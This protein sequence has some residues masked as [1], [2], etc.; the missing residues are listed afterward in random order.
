MTALIRA[1]L[2]KQRSIPTGRGLLVGMLTLIVF[3][4]LLHGLSLPP[5]NVAAREAQLDFVFRWGALFGSLFAS[6]LGA[7]SITGE[8]RHGTIRPTLLL[9][10]RRERV[11]AA[12]VLAAVV[13]GSAFGVLAVLASIAAAVA[14]LDARSIEVALDGADYALLLFGG[15]ATAALWAAI[16]VGLGAIVRQQVATVAGLAIWLLFIES[17]LVPFVPDVGRLAPGAAGVALAG[18]DLDALLGPAA[19]GALLVAYAIAAVIAGSFALARR[20]VG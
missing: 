1:E 2:L 14:S 10:P 5:D 16:G 12:K 18:I 19:G 9:T 11:I 6:L 3:A 7:L 13:W 15:T 17:L 20:D 4:V 8:F